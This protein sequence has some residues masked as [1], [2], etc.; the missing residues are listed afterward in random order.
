M[1]PSCAAATLRSLAIVFFSL[2]I[3]LSNSCEKN[4]SRNWAPLNHHGPAIASPNSTDMLARAFQFNDG[5]K[6]L[7]SVHR[8]EAEIAQ[9][10]SPTK[11]YGFKGIIAIQRPDRFRLRVLGPMDVKFLDLVYLQGKVQIIHFSEQ[12]QKQSKLLDIFEGIADDIKAIYRLDPHPTILKTKIEDGVAFQENRTPIFYVTERGDGNFERQMT[13][14]AATLAIFQQEERKQ[15]GDILN[16]TYR[17]YKTLDNRHIPFL[18]QLTREGSV[19][20]WLTIRV[21]SVSI[22]QPIDDSLFFEK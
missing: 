1:N 15:N 4:R 11:K 13:L 8:V 16:I 18:I 12:I 10:Q 14:Y 20:Y 7:T 9:S 6:T 21:E 2:N 19:S 3:L 5:Y 22:D 17:D